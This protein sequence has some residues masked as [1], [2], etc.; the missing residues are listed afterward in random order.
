L[1]FVGRALLVLLVWSLAL[2]ALLRSV[3]MVIEHQR[4]SARV[5]ALRQQYEEQLRDY[6]DLLAEGEHIVN[7]EEYQVKLLKERLG[8]AQPDETPIIVLPEED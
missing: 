2:V 3:E 7:D 1:R 5:A 6:A 4:T 8:Y